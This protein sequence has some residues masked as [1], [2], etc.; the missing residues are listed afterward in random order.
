M[1]HKEDMLDIQGLKRQGHSKRGAAKK[2]GIHRNTVNKYWDNPERAMEGYAAGGT[3]PSKLDAYRDN[4]KAWLEQDAEYTAQLL[5]QKLQSMGF[6][7]SYEIVKRYVHDLKATKQGI[8]YLR[9]ETEPGLQAQVDFG[10]F[11]VEKSNGE[12]T[13]YYI[14]CMI[15]GYSRRLYAEI[16]ERCDLPT[17]LDCHIRAFAFFGGVPKEILY[18]RMKNVYLGQLA[19]KAKFND[20]LVGFALHYGFKPLVAP[21]YAAWVKGKVER[22]YHYLRENFWRGY[23]FS[24]METAQKDLLEW[25]EQ[26]E[27]RVHGTTH[28]VVRIRFER[29]KDCLGT[30]PKQSF[31]TSYRL[32]REVRKDC[33]ILFEGN[34]YVL[35]YQW[36]RYKVVVRVKNKTLR[37]FSDATCVTTYDIPEG[38]GHLVQ[39]PEYYEALKKDRELNQR[40]YGHASHRKGRAKHTISPSA[41]RYDMEVAARPV[42]DYEEMAA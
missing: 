36:I 21:A 13:K 9:F 38:K 27:E 5:F 19:G 34:R 17:F 6:V 29:E 30:L 10:E 16:I 32:Y 12:S 3:R 37:V 35:P 8:A 1:K 40:K 25:L 23:A 33:T 7:G 42:S 24:G 41:P 14:F 31:D 22:S 18:D 26:K 2:L 15:L 28:E 20:S 4:L 39:H 11:M